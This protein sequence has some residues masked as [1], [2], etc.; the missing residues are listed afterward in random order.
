MHVIY[1]TGLGDRK[2]T[3]QHRA[4]KSWR[5]YGVTPH[6]FRVGWA[7]DETFSYKFKELL[8]LIDDLE[9]NG[10]KV[11]LVAV[12]AGASMALHAFVERRSVIGVVT[13]CGKLQR[14]ETVVEY[15]KRENPAFAESMTLLPTTLRNLTPS[16]RRRLYCIYPLS[17]HRVSVA[18]QCIKGANRR[19]VY[20]FGHVLTIAT[21]IIF[22]AHRNLRFLKLKAK[23]TF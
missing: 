14:P 21:Q 8:K 1:I 9:K 23:Q 10:E 19:R 22:G 15:V 13:I 6:F 5:L 12:S 11:G 2:A 3:W 7:D 18:D 16:M 4:V 17:D 20:S